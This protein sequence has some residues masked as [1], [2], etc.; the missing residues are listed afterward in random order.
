[1]A[2]YLLQ[3][4]GE[5]SFSEKNA[6][7]HPVPEDSQVIVRTGG[8]GGWGDPLERDPDAVRWDVIEGFVSFDAA[9]DD[10]GVVLDPKTRAVDE[11]ATRALRASR[12]AAE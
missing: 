2:C 12:K 4:P 7:R 6:Y 1:T 3:T 5:N 10:Y 8:G 9:R 11:G